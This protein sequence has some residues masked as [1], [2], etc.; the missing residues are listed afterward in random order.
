MTWATFHEER[1]N[2]GRPFVIAH[3]GVPKEKPENT[4]AS[5]ASA[6]EQGADA[7]ET[8]LRFTADGEIVLFH[9]ETVERTTDGQGPVSAHTLTGIKRLHTRRPADNQPIDEP[10]P[11]LIELLSMTQAQVPLLLE[12]KDPS[13]TDLRRAERLIQT[14][15]V[16]DMLEKS[17][18]VSF[19]AELIAAVKTV[20]P[21]IPAGY[22][23]I[24]DPLPPENVELVGPYWPLLFINPLYVRMAHNKNDIVAPL[25]TNPIPRLSYYLWLGV[26]ALLADEPG[27]VIRALEQR[28]R[29]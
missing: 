13:F 17:A 11:T 9:D 22:I 25:D 29:P 6:I 15:Q 2:M 26:D 14:L 16:Y 5:F 4:L 3:R 20:C 24:S 27:Q 8:D 12:L 1:Q 21:T 7:L 28:S 23:T 19:K 10:V 18:I